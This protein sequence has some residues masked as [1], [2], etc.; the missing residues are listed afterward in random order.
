VESIAIKR[1]V[2]FCR[3]IRTYSTFGGPVFQVATGFEVAAGLEIQGSELNPVIVV[4]CQVQIRAL[5]RNLVKCA[6]YAAF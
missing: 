5:C 2:S 4:N 1:G 6:F 3:R